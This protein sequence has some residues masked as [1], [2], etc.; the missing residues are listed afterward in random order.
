MEYQI[1]EK[2]TFEE[3][4]KE[5]GKRKDHIIIFTSKDDELNQ[6]ILEKEKINILL[7]SQKEK[8]DKLKQR[9]SGFNQ[10]MAK[11]A[12]KNNIFI[13][14]NLDEIIKA[15]KQEKSEILSRIKQNIKICNKNQLKMKFIAQNEE[16]ERN[17]YDLRS[18]GLVLGMPTKMAENL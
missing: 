15:E 11:L 17:I 10:V 6:K 5:I 14:I 7:L 16:N 2:N 12:K 3:A 1:I 13:G 8:K 18:L 4:R 9:N